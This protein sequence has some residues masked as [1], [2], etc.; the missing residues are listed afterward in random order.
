LQYTGGT[1]GESKGAVL[2]HANLI[3]N[4][5]QGEN[6]ISESANA[7][8]REVILPLPLYH[9]YA[10]TIAQAALVSGGHTVLIPN[11]RDI[12]G[13]VKE[14][15]N[16]QPS[17]FIGLN[18]LFVAL[19]NHEGFRQLD[20][21]KLEVSFSGGMAL[22]HAAAD[23]W[24]EVTGCVVVEGYGLTETS[25]AV[26]MNRLG[27][28]QIGSIGYPVAHT[29]VRIIQ[30]GKEQPTGT[31]GELCVKGPQ[32]MRGY[33]QREA[34]SRDSF[35]A[36]G[37]F[38]TGDIAIRQEDGYY[39]IVDRAKDMI[40]VSGFNVFPNEVED[41]ISAHPEVLE[42]AV[43]GVPDDTSGERVKAFVVAK[44]TGLDRNEIRDWCKERLTR[45]KVPKQVEFADELPKSNVGKILRRKLKEPL[46]TLQDLDEVS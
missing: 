2:T 22:T 12:D 24:Q 4:M 26:C 17:T 46:P 25:P 42:C 28:L 19:C 7:W 41:V 15:G 37:Y 20:F 44:S 29:D 23:L 34:D 13:F 36:D 35:T 6:R 8:Q 30:D 33:W 45:Y 11:P 9:I 27:A 18:T 32:V 40:I 38:R 10:F 43:I 16:W 5:L 14:L 21:S 3:A 39:R 1:T 31:P